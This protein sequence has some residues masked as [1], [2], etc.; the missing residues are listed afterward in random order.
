M[1]IKL[2]SKLLN[3]LPI[4]L[5]NIVSDDRFGKG[6]HKWANAIRKKGHLHWVLL[7]HFCSSSSICFKSNLVQSCTNGNC[8][9][10]A[11]VN[12][13][14]PFIYEKIL[15][16]ERMRGWSFIRNFCKYNMNWPVVTCDKHWLNIQQHELTTFWFW[17]DIPFQ[18]T[19]SVEQCDWSFLG[20]PIWLSKVNFFNCVSIL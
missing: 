12:K 8:K 11:V 16:A 18:N 1:K 20:R 17:C 13:K 3:I 9:I 19:D 2:N 10:L 7:R 6:I 14:E 4:F 5:R 15:P